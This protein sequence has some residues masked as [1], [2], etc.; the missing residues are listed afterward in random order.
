MSVASWLIPTAAAFAWLLFAAFLPRPATWFVLLWLPVQG[1]VQ[2]NFFNDSNATV[3]IY[4]LQILGLLL[5]VATKALK[6]PKTYRPPAVL[7]FAVPFVTWAILMVPSSLANGG[8]LLTAIGLRTY[9][10][11]LPIVWLGYCAFR[12]REELER[13]GAVLSIEMAVIGVVTAFQFARFVT[14][15]GSV[16]DVPTGYNVAGVLRPPGTF[17]TPGHLGMYVLAMVLLEVGLLGLETSWRR[18][19][20]YAAGLAAAV[21]ALVVN[22]QRATVV[23][24]GVCLP[25]LPL[26]ARKASAVKVVAISLVLA[27]GGAAA[28]LSVVQDAFAS[29]LR[30][31]SDDA[32]YALLIVPVE[33]MTEALQNPVSGVGLGTASP[34]VGRLEMTTIGSAES[35]M[36]AVVY[37]LGVPGLLFFYLFQI[38]LFVAGVRALRDTRHYD[39]SLFAASILAYEVA[40]LLQSWTYDPLHYPPSRVIFWFWAGVLLSLPRIS[41]PQM[42][43]IEA[44]LPNQAVLLR[45]GAEQVERARLAGRR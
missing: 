29:R 7:L 1:W 45:T 2:L 22:S 17:S 41:R 27:A 35:F 38:A 6:S 15:W 44:R 23:L 34:G 3:L 31:I 28:G 32:N 39:V 4:E 19:L 36:A 5:I 24:L 26:L 11:P 40:I 21:L 43:L 42:Q 20:A 30:S 37:Q 13:V 8:P 16:I 18:R 9:L 12:N 25:M 14:S 33:R 10:L